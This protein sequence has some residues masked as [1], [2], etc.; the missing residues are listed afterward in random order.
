MMLTC[1]SPANPPP[2]NYTWYHNKM[3]MLRSTDMTFWISGAF[4][5]HAGYYSCEAENSLGR[6]SGG[7]EAELDIQCE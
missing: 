5:R 6:G 3:E 2:T 7:Q 4:L 1:L